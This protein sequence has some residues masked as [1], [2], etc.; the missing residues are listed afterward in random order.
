LTPRRP[1]PGA[2]AGYDRPADRG[3]A[4]VAA[5]VV[6]CRACPRLTAYLDTAKGKFP[7]H[8]CRPVPGFGAA[9]ARLLVVGLAPGLHGANRTG[10][11][12]SFDS[13]GEWLYRA[14]HEVGLSDRPISRGPGDGLTL[15]D[16]YITGAARCAPPQNKPLPDELLRCR[17]F[18]EAELGRLRAVRVA[19]ALGRIAHEQLLRALGLR[20]AAHPF[21]H[22]AEHQLPG[23]RLIDSYHCSRQNTNTG[24]LTRAMF[25][26]IFARAVT[27]ARA[28]GPTLG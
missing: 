5:G 23:L 12:F 24:R 21:A 10:R 9:E 4:K 13:S 16:V 27:L 15:S 28:P 7:D 17:P 1:G 3:L 8:W 2:G 14:L 11:V 18:L 19:V 6:A 20:P 25:A 22:G 26:A